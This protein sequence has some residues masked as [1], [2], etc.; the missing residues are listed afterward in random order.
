MD[1]RKPSKEQANAAYLASIRTTISMLA[2]DP[3][4]EEIQEPIKSFLIICEGEN[5]EPSYFRSFP[6][7][8]KLVKVEGGRNSKNSLVDYAIEQMNK[9]ENQGREVWCVYDFDL[10]PDEKETQPQDFNSSIAKA[11]ANGIKVAWSN[12]AFELWFVL[13]YHKLEGEYTREQ[14]YAI[15]KEEWKLK[16]FHKEAKKVQ[17][18]KEMYDRIG[19]SKSESQRLAIRRAREL[20]ESFKPRTDYSNHCSCTT[21]YLLVEE[22][23]RYLDS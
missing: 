21:V 12:D 23:N 13:H 9:E 22:L 19:G 16:S 17:F 20:H 8:S 4:N 10:K 5:T 3:Y 15:L 14:L 6:I 18:C 1:P 11:E 2:E 7:P